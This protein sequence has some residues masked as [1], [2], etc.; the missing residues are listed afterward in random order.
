MLLHPGIS[1]ASLASSKRKVLGFTLIEVMIVVAIIGILS[2]VA[3]PSYREYIRRGD[4]ASAR[5]GLLEAQQFMER[6]YAVNSRYTSD[7]AGTAAV[8]LPVRLTAVPTESPKYDITLG[9]PSLSSYT[10]TAT[11]RAVDKCANLTLT[12]TGVK[13]TSSGLTVSD[14][15][16]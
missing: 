12:H 8:V 11:P 3:F 7:V 10:L 2:A 14:C 6:Y 1:V 9:A 4:R 16:K 5:A 15:W 13:G